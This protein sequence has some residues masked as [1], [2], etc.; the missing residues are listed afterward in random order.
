MQFNGYICDG[1]GDPFDGEGGNVTI[2][3]KLYDYCSSCVSTM[4]PSREPSVPLY[5]TTYTSGWTA[6]S[7]RFY[8]VRPVNGWIKCEYR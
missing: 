1:C 4:I 8:Y 5:T 3:E 7:L 6:D 2:E